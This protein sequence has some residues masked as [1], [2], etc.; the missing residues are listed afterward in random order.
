MVAELLLV[1]YSPC[2]L[3]PSFNKEPSGYCQGII[4][5]IFSV[6][7]NERGFSFLF[8]LNIMTHDKPLEKVRYESDALNVSV[9]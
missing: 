5:G 8:A 7:E 2:K 3:Y 6:K 1:A 4:G 9:Q